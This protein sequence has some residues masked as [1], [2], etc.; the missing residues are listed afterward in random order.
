MKITRKSSWSGI[1]RTRNLPVTHEQL[2]MWERGGLIQNVMPQLNSEQREWLIT[3]MTEEEWAE[4][5][6]EED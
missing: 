4:L 2:I 3:G 1:T 5:F 6:G